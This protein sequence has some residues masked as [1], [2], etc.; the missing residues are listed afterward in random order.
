MSPNFGRGNTY[1]INTDCAYKIKIDGSYDLQITINDLNI[2]LDK[3]CS[4]GYLGIYD[5]YSSELENKLLAKLCGSMNDLKQT[6]FVT[7]DSVAFIRFKADGKNTG[8]GFNITY[9]RVCGKTILLN[10]DENFKR[11]SSPNY[12]HYNMDDSECHFIFKS[13]KLDNSLTLRFTHLSAFNHVLFGT[14]DYCNYSYAMVYEGGEKIESKLIDRYCTISVSPAVVSNGNTMSLYTRM[15][16]FE[17]LVSSVKSFCGGDF[18][19][20]EGYIT[21]PV[22]KIFDLFYLFNFLVFKGYP[23]SY[24]QNIECIWTLK[25]SPGTRYQFE[26]LD[27]D[28]EL[29]DFCNGDYLEIRRF[30]SSGPLLGDK[31]FCGSEKLP[32]VDVAY[33]GDIWIKFRSDE[34]NVAKGFNLRFYVA[35]NSYLIADHGFISSPSLL[36]TFL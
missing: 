29:S 11:I 31:R 13:S 28:L 6:K 5:S 14:N 15:V 34:E 7:T 23:N 20:I 3:N 35:S 19:S 12:P 27:F 18:N 9:Q 32:Q 16:I 17:A 10:E 36:I 24:P 30:S 25:A 8:R 22:R 2:P 26:F 33:P 21:N 1:D 4:K